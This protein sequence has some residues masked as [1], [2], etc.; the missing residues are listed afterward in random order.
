MNFKIL[1]ERVNKACKSM[2]ISL[3]VREA[4]YIFISFYY[5]I[6]LLRSL[7]IQVVTEKEIA[8]SFFFVCVSFACNVLYD[9][10]CIHVF[11]SHWVLACKVVTRFDGL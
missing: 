10:V 6:F 4:F 3:P 5:V 8:I 11:V 1:H 2:K 7:S 9:I